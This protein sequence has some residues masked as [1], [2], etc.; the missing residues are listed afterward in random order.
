MIITTEKVAKSCLFCS[1]HLKRL[2]HK[3]FLNFKYLQF[4]SSGIAKNP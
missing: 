3:K 4:V 1:P 2:S